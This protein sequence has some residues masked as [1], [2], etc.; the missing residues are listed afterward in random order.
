LL[1]IAW[2]EQPPAF[3]DQEEQPELSRCFLKFVILGNHGTGK[4]SIVR[5]MT[6]D[7]FMPEYKQ[8]VGLDLYETEVALSS[9]SMMKP[10]VI[11]IS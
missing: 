2:M 5:R 4:T 3:T 11:S 10:G 6:D 1:E 7:R 8:T 9:M